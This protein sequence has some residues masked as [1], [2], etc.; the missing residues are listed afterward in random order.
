MRS[1]LCP[2]AGGVSFQSRKKKAAVLQRKLFYKLR[3]AKDT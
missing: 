3:I 1:R 2:V